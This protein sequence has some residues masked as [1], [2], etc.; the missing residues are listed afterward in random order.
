MTRVRGGDETF[1]VGESENDEGFTGRE[2]END[3][4]FAVNENE[5]AEPHDRSPALSSVAIV[6]V[7]SDSDFVPPSDRSSDSG[8]QADRVDKRSIR[9]S[10]VG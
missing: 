10:E 9:T 6:D 3:E 8:A 5:R 4:S 2:N 1:T 7:R